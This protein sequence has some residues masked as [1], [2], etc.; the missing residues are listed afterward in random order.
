[1]IRRGL[2]KV[3]YIIVSVIAIVVIF[4]LTLPFFQ[5]K[6]KTGNVVFESGK[7]INVEVADTFQKRAIGLM[8]RSSLDEYSG[9]LFI[10]GDEAERS[11]W[12]KDT[13]IPLDMIFID[14]G[15]KIVHI[16]K[17]AKPCKTIACEG[18]S[19]IKPA[20]YVVEINGGLSEKW[21]IEAGQK[22]EIAA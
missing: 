15:F 18:Y 11:F 17:E 13:L 1:M 16:Q 6:E 19:S 2:M 4:F 8:N 14:S 20:K 7:A 5:P 12:M 9:M 10:F 21:S 3:L 22:I